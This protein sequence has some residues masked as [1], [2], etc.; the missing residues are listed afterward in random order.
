MNVLQCI[1]D[2]QLLGKSFKRKLFR[3]DTWHN[4]RSFLCALFA[5][6]FEDEQALSVYKQCTGRINPP[7][8]PFR[9]AFIV[10]GRRSGKSFIISAIATFVGAFMDFSAYL[11]PGETPVIAVI[12]SDKTQAQILLNY[13]KAFFVESP[14][15]RAMVHNDLKE[16]LQLKSGISIE[17]MTGDFRSIR[18][19]TIVCCLLD[20]LAF[21]SSDGSAPDVELLAAIRPSQITI[22][23]SLLIG[24]SSPYSRKGVLYSE[25]QAHYGKDGD[26]TLIFQASSE[27]MNPTIPRASIEEAYSRD[28]ISA[29]SEYGGIFRSDLE[30]FLSLEL[31]EQCVVRN[32]IVL[33]PLRD[34]D[35]VGFVDPS[36]GRN[37]AMVLA[38][39]HRHRE[40]TGVLDCLIERIPPFSPEEVVDEFC[41]VLKQ[42]RVSKVTG[43]HYAAGWCEGQFV[44]R[45]IMYEASEETRSE[46]YLRFLPIVTSGQ[47]ELLDHQ[48]T[49]HQFISL[50]RRVARGGR[51]SVD[52]PPNSHD[53]CA[54]ATAGAIGLALSRSVIPGVCLTY[55]DAAEKYNRIEP[56]NEADRQSAILNGG[57]VIAKT[58]ALSDKRFG[59]P[60]QQAVA[61]K[62]VLQAP[63]PTSSCP[64]CG[65]EGLSRASVQ[66]ISA[67]IEEKCGSCGFVRIVPRIAD[68]HRQK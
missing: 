8:Q 47:C 50:E 39:A 35:Y 60:R 67:D 44:K 2:P 48:K 54:N 33:P 43:D 40:T 10:A 23:N 46:I 57:T 24:I 38:I 62:V 16:G 17:V 52:H 32:R 29:A 7:K 19:R 34:E 11:S 18:G 13:I 15:L 12:A 26:P 21:F 58:P 68:I 3:G 66:G 64:K 27:T 63:L 56:V 22:P 51:D 4:W 59:A 42:Y 31:I 1:R 37:D 30:S 53:D 25:H 28:P 5:L 14:I 36:G 9:E 20:E 6:P 55:K 41:G 65:R 49:K 61:T 45:G